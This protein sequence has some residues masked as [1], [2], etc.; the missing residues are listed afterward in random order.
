MRGAD[1]YAGRCPT[2]GAPF[3]AFTY[4]PRNGVSRSIVPAAAAYAT[5]VRCSR[6]HEFR[7]REYRFTRERGH[8]FADLSA[9]R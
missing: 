6:R 5:F 7:A 8:E 3:V 2:C 4:T 9:T 1:G